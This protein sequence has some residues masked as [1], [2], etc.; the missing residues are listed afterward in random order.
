MWHLERCRLDDDDG[1]DIKMTNRL[2][3]F[4]CV[5]PLATFERKSKSMARWFDGSSFFYNEMIDCF[6]MGFDLQ[7]L[8]RTSTTQ[9]SGSS[10]ESG[11]DETGEGS[12]ASWTRRSSSTSK[13]QTTRTVQQP[14]IRTDDDHQ[15]ISTG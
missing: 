15:V 1:D 12:G 9:R 2:K 7:R 11:K 14:T 10:F 5:D 4:Q 6:V 3:C 8:S 13:F